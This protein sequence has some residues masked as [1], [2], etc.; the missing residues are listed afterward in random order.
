[1]H[2]CCRRPCLLLN[3]EEKSSGGD[4]DD[5]DE[6]A[7][8]ESTRPLKNIGLNSD[9][10]NT[11]S[12]DKSTVPETEFGYEGKNDPYPFL[13]IGT[14]LAFILWNDIAAYD[15]WMRFITMG[16]DRVATRT[17]EGPET[18]MELHATLQRKNLQ[19]LSGAL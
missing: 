10:E 15:F 9:S 5:D 18:Y 2:K 7:E 11:S 4:D 3:L 14:T 12:S 6:L 8:V 1:M 13:I 16:D 19:R 17:D